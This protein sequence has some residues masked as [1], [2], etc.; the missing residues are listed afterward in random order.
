[1]E[2]KDKGKFKNSSSKIVG[3]LNTHHHG[4]TKSGVLRKEENVQPFKP[5]Y[6][7]LIWQMTALPFFLCP[8]HKIVPQFS[9][10]FIHPPTLG[11]TKICQ[12][13]GK[14]SVSQDEATQ[15]TMKVNVMQPS[16]WG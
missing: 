9:P 13:A 5:L 14:S 6:V 12:Q 3:F 10:S 2:E 16:L 8:Q 11:C 7:F 15:K 4:R 1:M